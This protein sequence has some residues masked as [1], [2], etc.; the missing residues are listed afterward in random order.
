[1]AGS[2]A[3]YALYYAP[4]DDTDLGRFGE[5]W[6]SP[7]AR[8]A[9]DWAPDPALWQRA[10]ASPA[11]YGFHATLKAPFR[12]AEGRTE[13]ELL[14]AFARFA[15]TRRAFEAPP[16][17]VQQFGPYLALV[18]MQA[19]PQ[20][21]DLHR[22]C[23]EEFEPFRAPLNSQELAKRQAAGLSPRRAELLE[24]YGYPDVLDQF[25]FHLTLAGPIDEPALAVVR[26]LLRGRTGEFA[27]Q[28]LPID[29]LCLFKQADASSRFTRM[30]NRI[31]YL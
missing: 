29:G 21:D 19:C 17:T 24:R 31:F 7:E 11:H 6:L 22:D 4:P 3:R 12:L 25:T 10:T 14:A 9:P 18:F 30:K 15:Q 20:M 2:S 26:Q 5:A 27:K 28:G 1:M 8:K 16:L 13:A 23:V